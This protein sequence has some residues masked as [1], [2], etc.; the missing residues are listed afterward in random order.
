MTKILNS[1]DNLWTW[2]MKSSADP[3]KVSSTIKWALTGIGTIL[4]IAFGYTNYHPFDVTDWNNAVDA[5]IL[6]IQDIL[7]AL[8]AI[9]TVVGLVR[10]IIL[11]MKGTNPV[12]GSFKK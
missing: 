1:F 11:T 8:S 5:I 9:G 12:V 3:T 10:K 7:V 2:I 6:S 4:T